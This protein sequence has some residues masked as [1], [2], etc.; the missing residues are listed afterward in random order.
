[1]LQEL[2]NKAHQ[3][4]IKVILDIVINHL[5]DSQTNYEKPADHYRCSNDLNANNWN[6]T[7][8]GS[9]GQGKLKF[10]SQFFP[11]FKS[12]YFFNRCGANSPSDM[13]G[14]EPASVYGDFVAEMFDFDTR[15]YDLQ[16][17]FTE[18][19]KYWIAYADVDGFRLDAAKHVS[20]DFIAYFSTQTRDYARSIGKKNFLVVGEV[21]GPSDWIAR[22]L[23]NMLSH[24]ADPNQHGLVPQSLTNRL[25]AIK[26]IYNQ[27]PVAPYPG[28][29]AAFAFAQGGT[30]K[31]VLHGKRP[32]FALE[33]YFKS[34]DHLEVSR[35]SDYRL[36]WNLLEIHDWPRFASLSKKSPETSILGL[37]YL[38]FSEGT[39]VIYYGMEQ[40][41]N[42]DCHFDKMKVGNAAQEIQK[43]C[44]EGHAHGLFRQ[45]MFQGGYV[46]LG[47]SVEKIDQLAYIGL[48]DQGSLLL[49]DWRQDPYL[50]RSHPVYQASRRFFH[51]RK[52]CPALRYGQTQFRWVN[53]NSKGLLAFSRIDR[54]SSREILVLLNTDIHW[55]GIPEVT[56]NEKISNTIWVNMLNLNEQAVTNGRGR[57]SFGPLNIEPLG[58]KIFIPKEQVGTFNPE[59]GIPTCLQQ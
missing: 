54:V 9:P 53:Y 31:E 52:S 25:L 27:N 7:P 51:L 32:S 10:S 34:D 56:V 59:V 33:A 47:S 2:V 20:E 46:R 45:D 58:V 23:G 5:C 14:T 30:A 8:G 50:D 6:G 49:S 39:P 21:A 26:D 17:I 18:L 22:R 41:F 38:A 4:Q 40:G 36:N 42:G 19:H 1:E 15:N 55:M 35:Q 29:N 44:S 43:I 37:A 28:M 11:P 57:L 3:R 16:E 12:Q 13:E 24:P 48:P